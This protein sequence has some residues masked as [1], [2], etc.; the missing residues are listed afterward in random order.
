MLGRGLVG[1]PGL[2]QRI[3]GNPPEAG[4]YGRWLSELLPAYSPG[5]L[6]EYSKHWERSLFPDTQ[7]W[8]GFR[9]ITEKE[10]LLSYLQPFLNQ[11]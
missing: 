8:M 3:L 4:A 11:F 9:K 2:G 10:Q 6:K 7:Y 5:R 1:D